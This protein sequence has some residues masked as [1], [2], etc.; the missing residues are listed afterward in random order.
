MELELTPHPGYRGDATGHQGKGEKLV[1]ALVSGVLREIEAIRQAPL[2]RRT[3]DHLDLSRY[4]GEY[5]TASGQ[6]L[7]IGVADGQ[8]FMERSAGRRMAL[9]PISEWR[10]TTGATP[11]N[12]SRDERDL[13]TGLTVWLNG[14]ETRAVRSK[15]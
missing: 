4:T 7:R 11:V 5:R 6:A 3:L 13:I 10:F 12:F 9:A 1:E 15:N 8:L 2:P 14:Q